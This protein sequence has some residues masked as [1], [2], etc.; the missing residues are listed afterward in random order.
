MA[1]LHWLKFFFCIQIPQPNLISCHSLIEKSI[2]LSFI[3]LKKG[4]CCSH[5]LSLLFLRKEFR[6]PS[7]TKF[8]VAQLF[9]NHFV[10]KSMI[11]LWEMITKLRDGE[12]TGFYNPFVNQ[13]N[14]IYIHDTWSTTSLFIMDIGMPIFEHMAPLPYIWFINCTKLMMEFTSFTVLYH[15]KSLYSADLTAGVTCDCSTHFKACGWERNKETTLILPL[16]KGY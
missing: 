10:Q 8:P 5:P 15:K 11:N 3:T 4:Q 6:H 14:Q 12:S 2:T 7:D 16:L 13:S 9:G 1:P